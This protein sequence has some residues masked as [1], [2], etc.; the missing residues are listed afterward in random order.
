MSEKMDI[1]VHPGNRQSRLPA[2]SPGKRWHGWLTVA[3]VHFLLLAGWE[4]GVRLFDVSTLILPP[5]TAIVA[6]LGKENYSW[7]CNTGVTAIE[8]FSGYTL[9]VVSGILSALLFVSVPLMM[10]LV[11]PL[12]LTLNM[13]PKVALGPL[14]IIWFSYGMG[15]NILI[16]FILAY[17]PVLLT[18]MRGLKEV[19]PD[20]LDLV[21]ALK[22]SRWQLFRYIQLPGSLPYIFSGMKIATILAVAGA[23]VG[24]FIASEKG[25]GYLM[26][27]VQASLDTAA[28]YMAIFLITAIGIALYWTVLILEYFFVA[29][30][31]R[32]Q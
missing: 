32:I 24:E 31:A 9:A 21:R 23:V 25:L 30:D 14:I 12:L 8:V 6:T 7:F 16:T 1:P 18:A 19:E 17:F 22:G 3:M 11:F 4:A 10:K 29:K 13:V 20:L 2:H 5:P 26:I 27:Q 15:S 28:V